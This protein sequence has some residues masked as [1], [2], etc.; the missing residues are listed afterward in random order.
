MCSA[1]RSRRSG[2]ARGYEGPRGARCWGCGL[3]AH[4]CEILAS[5]RSCT[6]NRYRPAVPAPCGSKGRGVGGG[7][8]GYRMKGSAGRRCTRQHTGLPPGRLGVW[9]VFGGVRPP[10]EGMS[11]IAFL[12][13]LPSRADRVCCDAACSCPPGDLPFLFPH[14]Q[15]C[16]A[17]PVDG[18]GLPSSRQHASAVRPARPVGVTSDTKRF[19]PALPTATYGQVNGYAHHGDPMRPGCPPGRRANGARL[20]GRRAHARA[21]D[22]PTHRPPAGSGHV[23]CKSAHAHRS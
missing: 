23:D 7:G 18:A 19:P 3:T 12:L 13:L 15:G 10:G 1:D 22:T 4:Q 9:S 2:G 14:P 6:S 11:S 16:P 5:G 21:A 8:K 17:R 20:P